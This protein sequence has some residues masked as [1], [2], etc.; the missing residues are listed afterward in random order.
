MPKRSGGGKRLG[1]SVPKMFRFGVCCHSLV[2]VEQSSFGKPSQMGCGIHRRV[3]HL[4]V[5]TWQGRSSTTV[6]LVSHICF[7]TASLVKLSR[8]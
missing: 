2:V 8:P 5:V 3:E 4:F 7:C 1:E 6:S